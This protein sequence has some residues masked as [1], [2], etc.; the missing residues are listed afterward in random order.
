MREVD[1]L[2]EPEANRR[3]M[4]G[5]GLSAPARQAADAGES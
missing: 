5:P 4:A 1:A 3:R 2:T